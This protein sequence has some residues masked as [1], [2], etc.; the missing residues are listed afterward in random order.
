MNV[1]DKSK[2]DWQQMKA[3]DATL[4]EE[5]EAHRRS[6]GKYLDKVSC[7]CVAGIQFGL[8]ECSSRREPGLQS[9]LG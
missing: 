2:A 7:G 3:G 5:L 6:G 8:L 9:R 4:E 1:L